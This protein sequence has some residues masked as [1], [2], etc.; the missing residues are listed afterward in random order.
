MTTPKVALFYWGNDLMSWLR[1]MSLYSFR[2]L[3]PDWK[4]ELH[5]SKGNGIPRKQTY[6]PPRKQQDWLNYKGK[7]WLEEVP[8]LGIEVKEWDL[9]HPEEPN[10]QFWADCIP[11]SKKSNFF[12]WSKL[13]YEGGVYLDMDILFVKPMT[14]FYNYIKDSTVSLCWTKDYFSIGVLGGQK[15]NKLF[16]DVFLNGFKTVKAMPE[17]YQ[18][19]GVIN[20]YHCLSGG[21]HR[22]TYPPP[23]KMWK[24]WLLDKYKGDKV[25]LFGMDWFYY[26]NHRQIPEIFSE[27]TPAL[28]INTTG[29]HWYAGNKL[30]Q[31]KNTD[32]T[33]DNFDKNT[34]IGH[35][36]DKI[37]DGK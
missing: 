34:S 24:D 15:G 32:W 22:G 3:N 28:G 2:K 7:N 11:A 31:R 16:N 25:K 36:L 5:V 8:D 21:T 9:Y 14:K 26:F 10:N 35:W 29:I 4:V 12:K 6:W 19:A 23:G 30:A 18:S 13:A 37:W 20:L 33:P 1:Y 27:N 17:A